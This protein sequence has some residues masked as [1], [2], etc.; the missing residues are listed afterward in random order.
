MTFDCPPGGHCVTCGDDATTM[1]VLRVDEG[2]GLALCRDDEG[3]RRTVEIELVAPVGEGD[4]LL[5][6]AGVAL[7]RLGHERPEAERSASGRGAGYPAGP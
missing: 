6:H 2:R 1:R 4:G 7:V 3:T 5:V